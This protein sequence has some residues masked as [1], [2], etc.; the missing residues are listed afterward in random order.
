MNTT[1]TIHA[2]DKST[3]MTMAELS[4][5]LTSAPSDDAVITV[6]TSWSGKIRSITFKD[7]E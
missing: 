3:G 5:A 2:A 7:P 6:T 4:D 1:T